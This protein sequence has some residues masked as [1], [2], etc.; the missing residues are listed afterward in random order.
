MPKSD[1]HVAGIVTRVYIAGGEHAP[2][3]IGPAHIVVALIT[4]FLVALA[5]ATSLSPSVRQHFQNLAES[6]AKLQQRVAEYD[7]RVIRCYLAYFHH[8]N[9]DTL[10]PTHVYDDTLGCFEHVST[11]VIGSKRG[12]EPVLRDVYRLLPPRFDRQLPLHVEFVDG[13]KVKIGR[14]HGRRN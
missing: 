12:V 14:W 2:E 10:S 4:V 6:D 1:A 5:C 9:K 8:F 13:H 7:G 11:E 3:A